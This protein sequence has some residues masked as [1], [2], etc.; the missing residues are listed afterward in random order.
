MKASLEMQR[1]ARL[2]EQQ[3]PGHNYLPTAGQPYENDELAY[4]IMFA[5]ADGVGIWVEVEYLDENGDTQKRR[6][7]KGI[8]P[9]MTT[10]ING[11]RSLDDLA[12]AI[13][14]EVSGNGFEISVL[15]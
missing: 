4:Q 14:A 10:Q 9:I 1:M 7:G 13:T 3:N 6:L 11:Y 15:M 5:S 8:W 12:G 2:S